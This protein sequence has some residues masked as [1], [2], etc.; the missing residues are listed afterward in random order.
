MSIVERFNRT[1]R[2]YIKKVCKDGKWIGKLNRIV[3]AY[4][5][6]D[7]STTDYSPNELSKN[8]KLQQTIREILIGDSIPAKLELAKFH[9][10]DRVRIHEKKNII[11]K[12]I[13]RIF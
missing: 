1:L 11:W 9:V 13:R 4:N 8:P 2:G 10:G 5:D 3:E 12:R 6:K 7:H